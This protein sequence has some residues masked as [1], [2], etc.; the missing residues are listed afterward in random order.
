MAGVRAVFGV[1]AGDSTLPFDDGDDFDGPPFSLGF[2]AG[3]DGDGALPFDGESLGF[4]AGGWGEGVA[5]FAG[6]SVGF[7]GVSCAGAVFGP[8]THFSIGRTSE[9]KRNTV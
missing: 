4:F 6:A 1:A 5:A 9:L 2:F 7:R 3:G 8:I